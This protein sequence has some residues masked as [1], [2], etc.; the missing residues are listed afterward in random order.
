[1]L[2]RAPPRLA[3][4]DTSQVAI[5]IAAMAFQRAV[6]GAGRAGFELKVPVLPDELMA[7]LARSEAYR[8]ALFLGEWAKTGARVTAAVPKALL[9]EI[10][11]DAGATSP[12]KLA[13]LPAE[14]RVVLLAAEA[15]LALAEGQPVTAP[16][17]AILAGLD[18]RTIRAAVASKALTP[19]G[20][21][22]P[23]R[24]AAEQGRAYLAARGVPGME[25]PIPPPSPAEPVRS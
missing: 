10:R 15:R 19:L 14:V 25:A 4:V 5:A 9:A 22:R 18:E 20:P 3:A 21:G 13:E 2:G 16:E 7:Q 24:F 6:R 1:M 17:L 8:A 12:T 23:M 11:E